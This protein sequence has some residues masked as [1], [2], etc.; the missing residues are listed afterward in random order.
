MSITSIY[1]NQEAKEEILKIY[2]DKLDSLDI[3]YVRKLI[4]TDFGDTNVVICGDQTRPPLV[5]VHGS[6][7]NAAIAIEPF[8]DLLLSHYIYAID[9]IGQPNFSSETRPS[10]KDESYAKW[11]DQVLA[12]LSLENSII[13]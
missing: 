12:S 4:P 13:Y 3:K 9:V 10:M 8:T 7:G 11:L 5:L 6:N 2:Q 1:S